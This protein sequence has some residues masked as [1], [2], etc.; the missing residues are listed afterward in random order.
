MHLIDYVH[1]NG[2]IF[3]HGTVSDLDGAPKS[4]WTWEENGGTVTQEQPIDQG[5]FRFLWNGIANLEVF[6]RSRIRDPDRKLDW[7]SYHVISIALQKATKLTRACFLVPA[8]ESDPN[9]LAWLQAL[10]VPA[11]TRT[12][13]LRAAREKVYQE[14]FGNKWRLHRERPSEGPAIDVYVFEPGA[15]KGEPREFYTLVTGGMSNSPMAVPDGASFRRA[16]LILYVD[17]PADKHV[18]LLRWLARLPHIQQGTWYAPGSTMT[19]GQPPQP[20]F[21]G[22]ELSCFLFSQSIVVPDAAI[23]QKLVL[24]GDP[25]VMLWVVPITNLECQF[26]LKRNLDEFYRVLDKKAHPL[27]LD[28]KRHSYIQA[29]K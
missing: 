20:I 5:T 29:R 22:S 16:E 17:E 2:S 21:E 26:I 19:N 10:S 25:T 8:K 27:V 12:D 15:Q 24:E 3:F 23:Q 14:R 9:F 13:R 18:N 28:E 6:R 1:E 11:S 7:V 4:T